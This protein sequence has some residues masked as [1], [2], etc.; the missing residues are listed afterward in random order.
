M[1]KIACIKDGEHASVKRSPEAAPHEHR[2]AKLNTLY[3]TGGRDDRRANL[4]PKPKV[5][6]VADCE[7][8]GPL[9]W[10]SFDIPKQRIIP[11][12]P[13]EPIVTT[14]AKQSRYSVQPPVVDG[15]DVSFQSRQ[16][17][18]NSYFGC[19]KLGFARRHVPRP[20]LVSDG[21]KPKSRC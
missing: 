19:P 6:G 4:V 11:F 21:E 12:A 20:F 9:F 10:R 15:C 7:V 16:S 1:G 13:P 14:V 3:A 5:D 17:Q 2:A 18:G 8:L